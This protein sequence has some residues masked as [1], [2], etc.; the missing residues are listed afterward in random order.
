MSSSEQKIISFFL[1]HPEAFVRM[2]SEFYAFQ[3]HEIQKHFEQLDTQWLSI[4]PN[5][6]WDLNTIHKFKDQLDWHLFS[7]YST[8][9]GDIKLIEEFKTDIG[10]SDHKDK[11]GDCSI[12]FNPN[13]PWSD[14]FIERYENY[15]DFQKLSW[16]RSIHW[17]EELIERYFDRWDWKALS[18]NEKLPWSESLITKYEN[19]WDWENIIHLNDCFPWNV[20]LARKYFHKIEPLGKDLLL[21]IGKLWNNAQ[22]VEEFADYVDWKRVVRNASLPWHEENL[23]ERWKDRL[24][25]FSFAGNRAFISD[26]EFFEKNLDLYIANNHSAFL[27]LSYSTEVPWSIQLLE[28]FKIYWGWEFLSTNE[29]LP[30]SIELVDQYLD[31]WSWGKDDNRTPYCDLPRNSGLINNEAIPWDIDWIIKYKAF[32]NVRS[33]SLEPIIWGKAFKPYMD[34]KMV[35]TIFRLI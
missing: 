21:D 18:A 29:G 6:Q 34:E 27:W 28:R 32:I 22:I 12:I 24:K 20:P 30:W 23:R 7:R 35:N 25:G 31:R 19:L 26:P 15:L 33:L 8:A 16:C 3:P 1:C 5:C 17:T 9:F 4:N 11:E 14:Q 13:V 2:V 10:W